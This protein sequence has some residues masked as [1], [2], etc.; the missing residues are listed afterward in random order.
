[1]EDERLRTFG[2]RLIYFAGRSVLPAD[3]RLNVE[4]ELTDRLV[5]DGAGGLTLEQALR[6]TELRLGDSEMDAAGILADYRTYLINR[7]ERVTE[8]RCKHFVL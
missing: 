6:E 4:R 1:M 7:I 2:L 8:F 5:T 3:I